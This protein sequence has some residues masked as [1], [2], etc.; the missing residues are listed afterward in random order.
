[1]VPLTGAEQVPK[2]TLG[3]ALS[4]TR[5][6]DDGRIPLNKNLAENAIRTF[7]VGHKN[8]LFS[9]TPNEVQASTAIHSLIE[10]GLSPYERLQYVFETL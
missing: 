3:K 2:R 1:M 8:W 5:F 7:V 6:L 10:T 9:H 4:Q